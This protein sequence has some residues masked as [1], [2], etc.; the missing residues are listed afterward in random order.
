MVHTTIVYDHI[1][2]ENRF[3]FIPRPVR[4]TVLK[5]STLDRSFKQL[6]PNINP[7]PN[8]S[9]APLLV[10]I[11]PNPGPTL[12]PISAIKDIVTT[13]A[14]AVNVAKSIVAPTKKKKQKGNR[15]S[16]QSQKMG[17]PLLGPNNTRR[18]NTISNLTVSAARPLTNSVNN[19]VLSRIPF[20]IACVPINL[21]Y[22]NNKIIFGDVGSSGI[23]NLDLDPNTTVTGGYA[24]F[25]AG[26]QAASSAFRRFRLDLR[27][28]TYEPCLG[29]S[30][31][32][33]FWMAYNPD[34]GAINTTTAG[35]LNI[36]SFN[37]ATC[38]QLGQRTTIPFTRPPMDWYYCQDANTKTTAS[39]RQT[40]CGTIMTRLIGVGSLTTSATLG[41]IRLR[42]VIEFCDLGLNV[43]LTNIS[44]SSTVSPPVLLSS[45]AEEKCPCKHCSDEY[46]KLGL[47]NPKLLR[48]SAISIPRF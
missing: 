18:G 44:Q 7:K 40:S 33:A 12:F 46:V 48:E 8:Y 31:D 2:I 19:P 24:V 37:G 5:N 42:G 25:G 23:C 43:A 47:D 26:I 3:V 30:R 41:I 17:G 39:E 15:S 28:I 29:T 32:G 11:E 45:E 16:R 38:V 22:A 13:T 10:G 21:D 6:L 1:M 4:S 35:T 14:K 20:D 27:E 9:P 36:S 34:G